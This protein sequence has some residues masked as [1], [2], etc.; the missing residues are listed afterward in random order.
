M[1]EILKTETSPIQID[2]IL[3][4]IDKMVYREKEEDY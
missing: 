3:R 4:H 2:K 1:L